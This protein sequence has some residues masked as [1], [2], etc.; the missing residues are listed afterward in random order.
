VFYRMVEAKYED[1]KAAMNDGVTGVN[2]QTIQL[3]SFVQWQ[4]GG[5]FFDT[6]LFTIL[7]NHQPLNENNHE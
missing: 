3:I 6:R 4:S 7:T 1:G 2:P 5:D